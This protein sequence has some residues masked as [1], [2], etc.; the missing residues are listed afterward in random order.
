[1]IRR[2]VCP[3]TLRLNVFTTAALD[4]IDHNPSSTTLE[5]S[6]HGTGISLFQHLTPESQGLKREF[7]E[8]NTNNKKR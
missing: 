4:N 5:G 8:T 7:K 1:M 3:P 6:F 2:V